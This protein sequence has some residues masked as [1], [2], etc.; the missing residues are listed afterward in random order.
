ME[1][2]RWGV[3]LLVGPWSCKLLDMLM[4]YHFVLTTN[5]LLTINN[6]RVEEGGE[7]VRVRLTPKYTNALLHSH[8]PPPPLP[9]TSQGVKVETPVVNNFDRMKRV[10]WQ[11]V[12]PAFQSPTNHRLSPPPSF[13]CSLSTYIF[14][15]YYYYYYLLKRFVPKF[16]LFFHSHIFHGKSERF[17][18]RVSFV[19]GRTSSHIVRFSIPYLC[20]LISFREWSS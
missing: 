9:R 17:P 1:G 19:Q 11:I 14:C 20:Y 5:L 2:W 6:W 8:S 4:K 15:H 16:G 18:K 12:F 3:L 10:D 13:S 7:K